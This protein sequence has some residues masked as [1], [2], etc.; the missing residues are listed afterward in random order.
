M[1]LELRV[2][3]VI[4]VDTVILLVPHH[5]ASAQPVNLAAQLGLFR[6]SAATLESIAPLWVKDLLRHV[7]AAILE[8]SAVLSALPPATCA[9]LEN[10]ALPLAPHLQTVYMAL[11]IIL[12]TN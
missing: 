5:V 11:H 10:L 12:G 6:V 7:L 9:L 1:F 8:D 4:L 2:S 3:T